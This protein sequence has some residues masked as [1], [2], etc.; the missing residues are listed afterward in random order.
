MHYLAYS[1]TELSEQ[2][3]EKRRGNLAYENKVTTYLI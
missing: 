1:I 2:T 3:I